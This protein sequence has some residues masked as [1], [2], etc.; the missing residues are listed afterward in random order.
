MVARVV[1][2]EGVASSAVDPTAALV[3]AVNITRR[4]VREA[5]KTSWVLTPQTSFSQRD[6]LGEA[7]IPQY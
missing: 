4:R 3:A 7:S 5:S 2:V 6:P 1:I